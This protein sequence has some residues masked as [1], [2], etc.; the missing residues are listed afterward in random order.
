MAPTSPQRKRSIECLLNN[1]KVV[2]D[3]FCDDL[4]IPRPVDTSPCHYFPCTVFA[5]RVGD[6]STCSNSCGK[7]KKTR[8]VECVDARGAWT[9]Y[10]SCRAMYP[11]VV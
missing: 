4:L 9:V 6:W 3:A 10:C 8:P 5:I 7:G 2:K 1:D 11:R